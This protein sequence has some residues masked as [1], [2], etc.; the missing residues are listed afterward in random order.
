MLK[1]ERFIGKVRESREREEE[2]SYGVDSGELRS[3]VDL[4]VRG[5]GRGEVERILYFVV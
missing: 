4:V 2:I 1:R 5:V 3:I